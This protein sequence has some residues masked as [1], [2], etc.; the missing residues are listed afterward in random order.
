MSVTT[1]SCL[2]GSIK[3][4]LR[5]EPVFRN[6]CHC[7]SCQKSTG[8]VFG[9]FAAY[10]IEQVTFTESEPSIMKTYEDKSPDSGS[11]LLR[12]FCG[13]CGSLIKCTRDTRSHMMVVPMGIID[14][15]KETFKP[16]ME[17]FCRN[18]ADWIGAVEGAKEFTAMPPAKA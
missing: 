10:N 17:F 6:L 8:V 3:G 18:R 15:D 13:K 12:S 4:E 2:C 14:G 16:D 11:V 5:G 1:A 7:S 9:S